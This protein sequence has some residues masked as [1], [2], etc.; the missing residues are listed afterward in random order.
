MPTAIDP[1]KH[2][3]EWTD[4]F[5]DIDKLDGRIDGM[6]DWDKARCLHEPHVTVVEHLPDNRGQVH[7]H[8]GSVAT[9]SVTIGTGGYPA[10]DDPKAWMAWLAN[11]SVDEYMDL[12]QAGLVPD[13]V[14]NSQEMQLA[15]QRKSSQEDRYWTMMSHLQASKDKVLD[16][17][18]ANLR[19]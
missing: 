2:G 8:A 15:V 1:N 14:K 6:I 17:I 4:M 13:D 9:A 16:A 18:T 3:I 7:T 10:T 5:G 19:A 11:H 12:L